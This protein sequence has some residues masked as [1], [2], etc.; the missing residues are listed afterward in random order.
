[1]YLKEHEKFLAFMALGLSLVI[2]AFMLYVRPLQD[3]TGNSGVLQILNL[4]IGGLLSAF[5]SATNALFRIND[6]VTIDNP[7]SKPVPVDENAAK[8]ANAA[9]PQAAEELPDYAR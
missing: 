3:S 8:I 1:M 6:K 9:V 2:L 4:I 5:G 7:P